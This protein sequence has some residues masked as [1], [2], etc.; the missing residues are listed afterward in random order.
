MQF[1]NI[2]EIFAVPPYPRVTDTIFNPHIETFS[3]YEFISYIHT[4]TISLCVI[5]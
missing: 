2:K 5:R 3:T 4:S 1:P